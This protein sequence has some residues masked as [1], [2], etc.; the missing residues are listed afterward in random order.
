MKIVMS[1][2]E[3]QNDADQ[4]AQRVDHWLADAPEGRTVRVENHVI[5]KPY[6]KD[7]GEA[8]I[9]ITILTQYE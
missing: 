1:C 4:H 8:T 6:A 9:L 7:R 2:L 5:T 3:T